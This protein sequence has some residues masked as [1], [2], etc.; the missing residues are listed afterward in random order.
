MTCVFLQLRTFLRSA[1]A[2]R[3][4]GVGLLIKGP[5]RFSLSVCSVCSV[6]VTLPGVNHGILGMHGNTETERDYE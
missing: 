2:A 1:G 3:G 6:A 5:R 4:N